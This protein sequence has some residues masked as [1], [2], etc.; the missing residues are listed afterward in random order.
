VHEGLVVSLARPGGNVTGVSSRYAEL[1]SKRLELLREAVPQLSR[2]A[3]LFNPT[4]PGKASQVQETQGAAHA[5]GVTLQLL[6]VRDPDVLEDAFAAM[7]G[8]HADALFILNHPLVAAY[9]RQIADLAVR[10]RLPT[11]REDK[12]Q[13][14]T[15][16]LMNSGMDWR[17]VFRR[18]AYY[19]DKILKGAK[20]AELPVEQPSLQG[21]S[22]GKP[23]GGTSTKKAAK[24]HS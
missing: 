24:E 17:D 16:C 1:I 2:L 7:T 13:A 9:R 5:L 8:A 20:P 6:E 22:Y 12:P 14:G 11:G 18:A 15:G 10:S 21:S 19:V 4:F 23:S 3:V